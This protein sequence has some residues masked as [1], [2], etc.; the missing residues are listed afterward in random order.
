[1]LHIILLILKIIGIVLLCVIGILLLALLCVLFVPV[2]YRI[3]VSREEGEDQP[4]VM[5]RVQVTWLL[6]LLNILIQYPAE[7]MVRVR[8]MIF[9]ILKMPAKKGAEEKKRE[10]KKREKKNRKNRNGEN[11]K[12]VKK[13]EKTD[14]AYPATDAEVTSEHAAGSQIKEQQGTD[15]KKQT[16]ETAENESK[17]SGSKENK[18]KEK[19]AKRHKAAQKE[20]IPTVTIK[21]AR[22]DQENE[23]TKDAP[24][25]VDKLR[26]IPAILQKILQKIKQFFENIQY[27][28]R[29]LC[30]RIRSILDNIQ[31]YK[32]VVESET[33]QNSFRLC[34]GE[35]VR[36]LKSLKPQKFEG[37]LVVGMDDPAATGQILAICGMLY[38][39][40]G[41]QLDVAGDFE[42]KRIEGWIFIK[43]KI[44]FG[45]F[46]RVAV[47]VYFNKDI[48]KLIRL[49]KKEA[50]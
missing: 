40:F 38:P 50:V 28:I 27:T 17:E 7:V 37:Q 31:Y 41:G 46:L 5:V 42:K 23:D 25:F 2:R 6:H 18:S 49:L 33:F 30:D 35:L 4:P 8:V 11:E 32:E 21:A 29:R 3:E 47:R 39:V 44:R 14:T 19:G 9:T 12:T 34:R 22:K 43:G 16:K 10:K 1:M 26:A 48:R 15:Q 36:I 13:E 24:G 45:T 20:K